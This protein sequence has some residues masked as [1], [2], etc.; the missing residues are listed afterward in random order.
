MNGLP[1]TL[2]RR[3]KHW[4]RLSPWFKFN[5]HR[6][7]KFNARKGRRTRACSFVLAI[8]VCAVPCH[9]LID[10]GPK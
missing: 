6:W 10:F 4:E 7:S 1:A 9:P 2:I 8:L 3:R 5:E